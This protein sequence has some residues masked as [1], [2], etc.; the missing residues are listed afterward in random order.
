MSEHQCLTCQFALW[1]VTKAGKKHPDGDGKCGWVIPRIPMPASMQYRW[2]P[3]K[4][5]VPQ[6]ENGYITRRLQSWD[7]PITNC[8]TYE[9]KP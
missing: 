4:G 6:P 2:M 8:P 9:A 3:N 1:R 5:V 7:K